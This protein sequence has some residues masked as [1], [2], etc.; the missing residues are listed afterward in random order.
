VVAGLLCGT[1]GFWAE[2]GWSQIAMPLPW[3]YGLL[4]EGALLAAVGGVAAG[5]IGALFALAL[6][7]RMPSPTV[8]RF[9]FVGAFALLLAC[10]IDAGVKREP[11]AVASVVLTDVK[12][13]DGRQAMA[14]VRM[15]PADAARDA[16]WFYVLAWQGRAP[17]VVEPLKRVGDGIYRT[18]HPIPLDGSWKVGLRLN[19][20]Y[21]RGA[22]PI[23]LP[24]DAGLPHSLQTLPSVTSKEELARA[25]ER[26]AGS[27][28]PAPARFTRPFGDDSLIVLRE[29]KRTVAD[30]LWPAGIALVAAIWGVFG[31]GLVL[32]LGRMGRGSPRRLVT[33]AAA[34]R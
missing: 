34:P 13:S 21:D 7:G 22:V 3:T 9:A 30:W 24:V 12:G 26:S 6:R 33:A 18:T 17:R 19:R 20:G 11:S 14:T 8:A 2:Y 16:N 15:R 1:V 5:V 10:G 29:A 23:R 28:L 32:G 25:M 31:L 27:E 4:P